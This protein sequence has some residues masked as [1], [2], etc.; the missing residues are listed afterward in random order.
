MESL[1]LAIADQLARSPPALTLELILLIV[2]DFSLPFEEFR[3]KREALLWWGN[4]DCFGVTEFHRR[5]DGRANILTL[6]LS[7]DGNIFDGFSPGKWES[8][9]WNWK[10][11]DEENCSVSNNSR[12]SCLVTLTNPYSSSAQ[13]FALKAETKQFAISGNSVS[14]PGFGHNY[15]SYVSDDCNVETFNHTSRNI[16]YDDRICA[17]NIGIA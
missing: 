4:R 11:G 13:T 9:V 2:S 7:T 5:C 16:R 12:Q 8:C 10:E 3:A 6:I 14:D 15:D 1:W 17:N